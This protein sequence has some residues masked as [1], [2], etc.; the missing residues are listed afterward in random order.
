LRQLSRLGA[1]AAALGIGLALLYVPVAR[2]QA[3][4]N[5]PAFT[6]SLAGFAAAGTPLSVHVS[7]TGS[8]P[9]ATDVASALELTARGGPRADTPKPSA[10]VVDL[11]ASFLVAAAQQS[12]EYV[13]PRRNCDERARIAAVFI[14]LALFPPDAIVPAAPPALAAVPP[15]DSQTNAAEP[16]LPSS[17]LPWGR[18]EV[19]GRLDGS[20][21][22]SR[23]AAVL[24]GGSM[25]R[26]SAGWS[27][28]L[29]FEL[30]LGLFVS[31]TRDLDGTRVRQQRFPFD[32]GVRIPFSVPAGELSAD[33]GVTGALFESSGEGLARV[34]SQ[35]RLDL[36]LR[37]GG[38]FRLARQTRLAPYASLCGI[39]LPRP[40]AF[41]VD[42]RG[43]V[44][45][46][47]ALRLGAELG[48]SVLLQ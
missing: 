8:C 5:D 25:V 42:G 33:V 34:D 30:G 44:G 16:Q 3:R 37:A 28:S 40:Y 1:W 46:T 47:A 23:S 4:P 35:V 26:G 29:G 17:R 9:L 24:E 39:F 12:Q 32:A 31:N 18:L 41:V 21:A 43:S 14:A 15:P 19:G 20:P 2:A 27:S 36:G 11:G 45:S 7:G 6:A 10:E 48:L 13:D 22:T 38:T